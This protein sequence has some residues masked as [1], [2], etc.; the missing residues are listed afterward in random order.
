MHLRYEV[1]FASKRESVCH[2]CP[3]ECPTAAGVMSCFPRDDVLYSELRFS[4]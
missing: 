3:V 2:P 4:F 1:M